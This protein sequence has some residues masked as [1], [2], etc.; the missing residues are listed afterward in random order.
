MIKISWSLFWR[1]LFHCLLVALITVKVIDWNVIDASY[2]RSLKRTF[3]FL[4]GTDAMVESPNNNQ[5]Y[6]FDEFD[7]ALEKVFYTYQNI[8]EMSIASL[9]YGYRD[10]NYNVNCKQQPETITTTTYYWA[11]STHIHSSI[12]E[13]SD[14]EDL[15]L[16]MNNESLFFDHL[17]SMHL[18][19]D[20][21]S[22][23]PQSTSYLESS[24]CNYW[25]IHVHYKFIAQLYIE[26][27]IESS[28]QKSCS[29]MT[30]KESF[31]DFI[32]SLEV[33][34]FFICIAY[35]TFL[36]RD[37]KIAAQLFFQVKE[38]H[39]RAR[40]KYLRDPRLCSE[41]EAVAAQYEWREIPMGIKRSFHSYWSLMTLL[42]VIFTFIDSGY[43]LAGK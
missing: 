5:I 41:I 13:F 6:T 42:G 19:F 9:S 14:I 29:A 7:T 33:I 31:T 1:L 34:T 25:E 32:T 37:I 4:F 39:G 36:F 28:M 17:D 10:Q 11:D 22:Y 8:K 3:S 38:A 2:G 18:A 21:C 23:Q 12:N 40:L 24:K 20:L 26:V 35:A 43:T 27:S 30:T 15:K 16:L